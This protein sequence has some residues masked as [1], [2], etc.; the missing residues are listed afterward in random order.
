MAGASQGCHPPICAEN[1]VYKARGAVSLFEYDRACAVG[2]KNGG[3]AVIL[4][5]NLCH[6]VSPDQ[7][8][9]PGCAALQHRVTDAR[10]VRVSGARCR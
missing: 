2:E 6:R 8:D 5:Y 4:V 10:R 7:Q 1:V 3:R 9:T